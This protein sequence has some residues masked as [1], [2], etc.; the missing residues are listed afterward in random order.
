MRIIALIAAAA[1]AACAPAA[2]SQPAAAPSQSLPAPIPQDVTVRI[3]AGQRG[4][5][6][7][8][9]VGERF[10]VALVGVPT[11]GYLWAPVSPPSFLAQT[12]EASGPTTAA[13]K[14]PGFAGGNHWE[15]L[16]FNAT[17]PGR[18]ELR[19]EQRRP[20][21]TDTPPAQTFSVTIEA[22]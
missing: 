16:F 11:A 7:Q 14:Q 19:L 8:V 4:Q 3:G 15:V 2:Q 5:V 9:R 21:E 12:G 18:G 20:W 10:A 6:V 17:A 1:L 22:R 13:Q